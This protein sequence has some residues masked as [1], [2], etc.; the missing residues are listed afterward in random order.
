MSLLV[1]ATWNWQRDAA[2]FYEQNHYVFL[3]LAVS[4]YPVVFGLRY[5]MENKTELD[6]GK[7]HIRTFRATQLAL[8]RPHSSASFALHVLTSVG[9]PTPLPT[10]HAPDMVPS[11]IFGLSR[12]DYIHQT[13]VHILY[14][15]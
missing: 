15:R 8:R 10:P 1:P 7:G 6:L 13:K 9:I 3:A 12:R 11:P 14:S 5:F 4:Y 2:G